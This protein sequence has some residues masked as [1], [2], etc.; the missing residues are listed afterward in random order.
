MEMLRGPRGARNGTCRNMRRA[1]LIIQGFPGGP[2]GKEPACNAGDPGSI[3][4][5]R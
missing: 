1:G 5:S 4:G 2:D 3:P